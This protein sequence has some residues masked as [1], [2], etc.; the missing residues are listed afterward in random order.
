M[1]SFIS[2]P[3]SNAIKKTLYNNIKDYKSDKGEAKLYAEK[4]KNVIVRYK[5]INIEL[6]DGHVWEHSIS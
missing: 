1:V 5:N 4:V 3:L 2:N 6:Y